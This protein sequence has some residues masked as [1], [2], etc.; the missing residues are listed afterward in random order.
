MDKSTLVILPGWG[1]TR[2]TWADFIELAKDHFNVVCIELPCFGNEP[3]P[4]TVWGVEEYADFVKT[5][6][7]NLR[8]GSNSNEK[9]IILGHSFGGQIAGYLVG[10]N[11]TI[12][13]TLILSG[14]AIFRKKVS[15]KRI[16]FLPFAKLGKLIFLLPGLSSFGNIIRRIFYK[17]IDSP[18]YNETEGMRREIFKK[19]ISQNVAPLLSQIIVPTLVITGD[20]DTYVSPQSSKKIADAISQSTFVVVPHGRHGLHRD[21][22][23]DFLDRLIVFLN[24]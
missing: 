21:N 2:E 20:C 14:A 9:V 11:K 23:K 1:G 4:S 16:I 13:D 24:G 15:F 22:P 10:T 18:D 12:C 6:I 7:E 3:C 17:M 19:I 5:K 8:T